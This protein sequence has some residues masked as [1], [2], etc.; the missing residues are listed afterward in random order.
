MP[1][2]PFFGRCC[3]AADRIAAAVRGFMG[4]GRGGFLFLRD[5]HAIAAVLAAV[6][7][8]YF[9]GIRVAE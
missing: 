8:V 5:Q 1:F 6:Y 4:G 2:Y 3:R 7:G 9:V